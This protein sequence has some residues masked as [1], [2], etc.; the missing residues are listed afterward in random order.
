[1]HVT[2]AHD[3][4]CSPDRL[5][6]FIEEPELQKQWMKGLQDNQQTSAGPTGVGSTFRMTIK[7]GGKV[8]DY[9]GTLTAYDPPRHLAV[10][11]TG[12]N[13]PGGMVLHVDYRLTAQNGG[14]HLDYE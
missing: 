11:M 3:F 12:K 10:E 7:E 14:T 2:F 13:F 5:W 6:R 1:M 4:A 8:A 9:D